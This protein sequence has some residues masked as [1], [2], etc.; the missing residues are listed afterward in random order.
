MTPK[1]RAR[2]DAPYLKING[3]LSVVENPVP[4]NVS[5]RLEALVDRARPGRSGHDRIARCEFAGDTA[6]GF[7]VRK[8]LAI[9][10]R[11]GQTAR[12]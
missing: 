3:R 1:R 4:F 11:I 5:L 8:R 12:A 6:A 7:T 2:S 9:A 10:R